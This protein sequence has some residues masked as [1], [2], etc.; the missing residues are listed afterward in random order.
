M[1]GRRGTDPD[2][3]QIQASSVFSVDLESDC[4][5]WHLRM[6][7]R[8]VSDHE[9]LEIE[10]W[11]DELRQFYRQSIEVLFPQWN[12][13]KL[14]FD[15]DYGRREGHCRSELTP[16]EQMLIPGYRAVVIH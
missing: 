5:V 14:H 1:I 9:L 3:W 16:K 11:P 12:E 7:G 8:H 10:R 2:T 13:R 15:W 4:P 6:W